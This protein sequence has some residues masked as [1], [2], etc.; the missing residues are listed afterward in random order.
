MY[1]LWQKKPVKDIILDLIQKCLSSQTKIDNN[2][3]LWGGHVWNI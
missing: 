1:G 2:R 3:W